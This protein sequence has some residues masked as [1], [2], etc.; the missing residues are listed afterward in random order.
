[1]TT[2]STP[3]L[4]CLVAAASLLLA[5]AASCHADEDALPRIQEIDGDRVHTL[6]PPDR[7]PSIDDPILVPAHQ[8]DFMVDEEPVLGVEYRG[9]AKA[10]SLWHLDRHEIVNDIF[11]DEPVAVTW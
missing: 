10:Y 6:L 3:K 1:M 2:I 7:I 4:T 11:A 9:V 8:A 5:G